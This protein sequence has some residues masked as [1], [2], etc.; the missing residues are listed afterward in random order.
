MVR[1]LHGTLG[2]AQEGRA[3]L[4][5]GG[6]AGLVPFQRAFAALENRQSLLDFSL[7][8]FYRAAERHLLASRGR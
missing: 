3:E 2:A 1:H 4:R 6:H 7:T 5:G 8:G